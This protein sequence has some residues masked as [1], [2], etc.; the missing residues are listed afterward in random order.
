MI[1]RMILTRLHDT[2]IWSNYRPRIPTLVWLLALCGIAGVSLSLWSQQHDQYA[3]AI[4]MLGLGI[5][6]VLPIVPVGALVWWMGNYRSTLRAEMLDHVIWRG[7]EI[8]LDVGCG[9]GMLLNGAALRLTGGRAVGIDI[10]A[11]HSGGGDVDMLWKN[12]RAEGVAERIEFKEADVRQMPFEDEMFDAVFASG[13]VHHISHDP[14]D[15]ERA[16]DEIL[17][18]LKP[19][20]QI[21]IWDVAALVNDS[22]SRMQQMGIKSEVKATA[23]FLGFDTSMVIAQK[24]G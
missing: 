17:R 19:G 20:G 15:Y 21:V 4:L 11:P 12:A 1:R 22:A 10:W 24:A 16:I 5:V 6:L 2:E 3:L 18:V 13:A 23:P 14:A 7:D 9:S 8:V